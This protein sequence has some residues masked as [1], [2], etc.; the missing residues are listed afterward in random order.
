VQPGNFERVG[1]IH[2]NNRKQSKI[3]NRTSLTFGIQKDM[4]FKR[5][6]K[7][8]RLSYLHWY[9]NMQLGKL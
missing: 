6:K 4:Q 5:C 3:M 1:T 9:W 2:A 8:H 7:N